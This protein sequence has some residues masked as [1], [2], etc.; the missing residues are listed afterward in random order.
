MISQSDKFFFD[1][2][3]Y[4]VLEQFLDSELTTDLLQAV[5]QVASLR[6]KLCA[7]EVEHTGMTHING[8]N[9]RYFYILDDHPLFLI[10]LDYPPIMAYIE[11]LLNSRP[12]HHAS[13]AVLEFGPVD[14]DM[15]WHI[16][17]HDD[18]YRGLAQQIPLLQLKVG[19]YLTNMTEAGQGNLSLIPGSHKSIANPSANDLQKK[20]LF[21]GAIQ[22][23]AS[24]GTAILFHNAIWHSGGPWYKKDGQRIMLY[25]AYEHPWMIASAEHWS[26]PVQFYNAL[27]AERRKLFHGFVFDP[28]EIRWG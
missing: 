17:G 12:H 14:R 28:P 16:D 2:N 25:Y 7:E 9:T 27:S 15:A 11:S 26:Y 6:R 10:M 1:N 3:G 23:C 22:V 4:L 21:D 24:V 18:G 19:Y 20:E 8:Q 5:K 13:D